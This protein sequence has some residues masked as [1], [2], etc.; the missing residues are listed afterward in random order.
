M[1]FSDSHTFPKSPVLPNTPWYSL[2][3]IGWLDAEKALV[4]FP[5]FVSNVPAT[6][7]S[8]THINDLSMPNMKNSIP[9]FHVMCTAKPQIQQHSHYPEQYT[10]HIINWYLLHNVK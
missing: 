3:Y 7:V 1:A 10:M 9:L 8:K 2:Y 4:H 6:I 5:H